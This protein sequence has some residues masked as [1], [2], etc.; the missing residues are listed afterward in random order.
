MKMTKAIL[1]IA[2][3]AAM[4]FGSVGDTAPFLLDTVATS[5]SPVGGSLSISWDSSWIGG[6]AN[7]TVVITDNGTEIKRTTGSGEFT[8]TFSGDNRHDLAYTTYIGGVAQDK[9]YTTTAYAKCEVAFDANGGNVGEAIRYVTPAD[10]IGA[11]P[12]PTRT[13]Y[14]FA[15]W[16]TAADGGTQFSAVTAVTGNVTYYAHWTINQY[17]VT[18]DADGGAVGESA[19]PSVTNTRDYGSAIVAPE[20]MRD[21][22]TFMGWQPAVLE[23]V[24]ASNVTYTAQWRINQYTVIFNANG[25]ALGESTLPSVTNTQDYGGAIV[26]PEVSREGHT[27]TG[28]Q[29]AL[30]E[31]V[32]ASNVT[33]TA[34]WRINQYAVTFDGN[35]GVLGENA[36]PS[37]TNTQEYGSAIV[38]PEVSREGY[39]F[40]GWQPVVLETVP[41]SNV[42][43][44]AQWNVNQYTVTFEGN[45]GA[46]GESALPRIVTTQDYE[47]AIVAPMVT[48]EWFTFAGWQPALLETMPARDVSYTAQWRRWGDTISASKMGGKTMKQLYPSDYAYMTTVV[49]EEGIRELPTGFFNGCDNVEFVTWPST[50]VEFGIDDIPTKIR[51]TLEYDE[52]GFLIYNNWVLDYQDR[53]AS[54]VAIPEGVVG[55]GRGA[56]AE[57]YDLEAV[58]MPES[59]RSIARGAFEGCTYIQ[60]LQFMSGLRYVGPLAFE[61]CT[62]LLR[63]SFADGVEY[64]GESAF[65]G[66]WQMQSVRL[67]YT[68]TYVGDNAFAGCGN[69]RGVTVPTHVKTMQELFPDSCTQIETAEVAEGE[70]TVMDDMFAGCVALRGGATQTDMSMIPNTVTNIGARAFKDCMSLTAFVVPDSVAEIGEHVFAGCSSLWNVTLSRMLSSI[71]DYAF[72]GCLMLET[73]VVP[74]R[75][76]YLGNRFFS[77]RTSPVHGPA[78]ENSLYYLCTNAPACHADAYAAVVGNMTTYV[79]QDSRSW[80]GRQ[81]SRTLP[82]SWNGYPIT[83]WTPARFD[84][85]FD[86]NGGQFDSSGGSTWSEKQIKDTPYSLPSTE[87]VRPGWAF[88]GWWT[89]QTGGAEVR[90]TTVVTATRTHTLYAHWRS[91]GNKVT[92]RFNSN[93]G[94]VVT[95][96]TQDYVPGQTF[97]QFPV[98]TR[99][100]YTFQGW[101]TES[102]NGILMTEA[103]QVPAA[104]M[105]LFAHWSPITYYVRFHPNGGMGD[106]VDQMFVFDVR[107]ALATHATEREGFAFTGWATT[108]AGQVRYAEN[109]SVVNLA[110]VQDE[111]VDL[112]AVWSGAGYSVRF[113]S[114]GGTGIM[115]NQ[116]IG[117]GER[118]NLWPCAFARGGYTFAGWAVSPTDAASGTVSYRDG[119]AVKDLA[120]SNGATVPLYA[121]WISPDQTVRISFDTN[122]GSVDPDYW[123]CVVGTT[124]EAFPTPT[125]PGFTFAGWWTAKSGGT[126]VTSIE[127]VSGAQ[128]FY[129]H[130]SENGGVDPG[131]GSCTVKFNPNGGSVTPTSR[132]VKNGSEVGDLPTPVRTGYVFDGWYTAE[133]GGVM[134]EATTKVAS[135]VTYY[136]HWLSLYKLTLTPDNTKYGT[137]TGGG[138][139]LTDMTA[140]L[141]ATAKTGNAFA[142]WFTDKACTKPLNPAGYDN[143]SPTVKITMPEADT[144][145]Y[146]KFV[147]AAEAKK[148]LKFSSATAKLAT[149]AAKAT[150]G[151]TFSLK[152]GISSASLVTV[153]ATGLPKGLKI[154]KATGA[155]T[156]TATVPGDFTATVTVK[157][158]AG[159]IISQKVKMTIEAAAYARGDF[160]GTAKPGKKGDPTAYL[161]FTVAKTGKVSG[162]V[163]YKGKA[164]SFKSTLSS[165]TA[166]KAAF[167]P[168][169]KIGKKTFKPGTVTVKTQKVGGLSL[170]EAANSKGTFAAQKKPELVKKGKVLAKLVGKTFKFTKKT[171]NSGLTKSKDKLE[172][173]LANGDAVKVAG[174]VGG[175]KLT[176]IS[177]VTLV[178]GKAT[179]G[180]SE[181]YTLYVDIIDAK[182]KYERTLVI[183]ATVSTGG[184]KATAAFAK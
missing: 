79:L 121:V 95:P 169:V 100:G 52:N 170:V 55:I 128:T 9:V 160:Y 116:T 177:W 40:T 148:S 107:Q 16:W 37:V 12:T 47:S 113:D 136:A 88:E 15:G 49:L 29:P 122:G 75:V 84:V 180:G 97:G 159:N 30:L 163:N 144:T 146:A 81:G 31:T 80:D 60:N 11:L 19:L 72:Y 71:P 76:A 151:S 92:M 10:A 162:K 153:T 175:K 34:Q 43:Y 182:L 156:G 57:M 125:R 103:T 139:Y 94:T 110:E 77:G 109:A 3:A 101:W 7:A 53:D 45:G 62:S 106:G 98:P 24:P 4:V 104:N 126:K 147:T 155:I 33:Y 130:W 120:T 56:F 35:G 140:T 70:T 143:R 184:V 114:N 127:Y 25:G 111:V 6:N 44:T 87:P 21:G 112:Y 2:T 161:Q 174:V 85:T 152:L 41:A 69:I 54:E 18:F 36:L 115:D 149:T 119:A 102:V 172:V 117:I 67:P 83:Y 28:W 14:T 17:T 59:L 13:G 50:L 5:T 78:I 176:A 27:F 61:D 39:T 137:V 63:A 23:T 171:K 66:C 131:D 20:A 150:A 32:P 65:E 173:K 86:A 132:N 99:R 166:S 82:P 22:C 181:V 1:T 68:L 105:E 73:M 183:K 93:G 165:C 91:L 89:E 157:D 123:D 145:V 51:E 38:A 134:V 42:T 167:T 154:D 138:D 90:Y 179:K 135:S 46:L 141:K 48:R 178:S 133:V 124:V 26:A 129:A 74:E 96:G 168:K 64:I 142:G 118:Q 58:A 158:A 8:H 164:Y 108:P